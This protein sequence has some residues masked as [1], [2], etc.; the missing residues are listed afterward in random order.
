MYRQQ[1][2]SRLRKTIHIDSYWAKC[3]HVIITVII[4]AIMVRTQIQLTDE[5]AR[6][7]RKIASARA[8][9]LPRLYAGPLR[10]SSGKI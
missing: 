7:I 6:A 3:Y 10:G 2:L 1:H 5:Q 4:G 8:F 9:Q